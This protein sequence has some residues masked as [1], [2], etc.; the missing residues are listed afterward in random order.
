MY[1]IVVK[2]EDNNVLF[3]EKAQ[4]V[5]GLICGDSI[6]IDNEYIDI[7]GKY[8]IKNIEYK[9]HEDN[10]NYKEIFVIY[11]VTIEN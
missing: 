3:S 6:L 4:N 1:R 10:Y 2:S 11:H 7:K 5:P 8:T 9:F